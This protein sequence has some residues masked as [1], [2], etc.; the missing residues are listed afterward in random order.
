MDKMSKN[1]DRLVLNTLTKFIPLSTTAPTAALPI[2]GWSKKIGITELRTEFS[3][4]DMKDKEQPS[5]AN[6]MGEVTQITQ[7]AL[8]LYLQQWT[9]DIL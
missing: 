4:S 6:R 3:Y 5:E 9:G 2:L 1:S 7:Q 8:F